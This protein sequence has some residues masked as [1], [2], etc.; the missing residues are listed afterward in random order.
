MP[1]DSINQSSGFQPDMMPIQ[2]SGLEIALEQLQRLPTATA[3]EL[4]DQLLPS[5]SDKESI[6]NTW[7][8]DLFIKIE[9]GQADAL[10][11]LNETMKDLFPIQRA[12][13]LGAAY[14]LALGSGQE[15]VAA[16]VKQE[17]SELFNQCPEAAGINYMTS[18]SISPAT[19]ES[20][21]AELKQKFAALEEPVQPSQLGKTPYIIA[22]GLIATAVASILIYKFGFAHSGRREHTGALTEPAVSCAPG[23]YLEGFSCIANRITRPLEQKIQKKEEVK[24]EVKSENKNEMKKETEKKEVASNTNS[25]IAADDNST[26]SDNNNTILEDAAKQQPKIISLKAQET[27]NLWGDKNNSSIKNLNE[28]CFVLI[29][30][31]IAPNISNVNEFYTIS[32]NVTAPNQTSL[33]VESDQEAK[34]KNYEKMKP[35]HR[36]SLEQA[37]ELL[38]KWKTASSQPSLPEEPKQSQLEQKQQFNQVERFKKLKNLKGSFNE[39]TSALLNRVANDHPD[40]ANYISKAYDY[41][42]KPI[43]VAFETLS[44]VT[45]IATGT[46]SVGVKTVGELAVENYPATKEK[47]VNLLNNDVVINSFKNDPL[48]AEIGST[49]AKYGPVVRDYAM[50]NFPTRETLSEAA[51][52]AKDFLSG[53]WISGS[54][55]VSRQYSSLKN[56]TGEVGSTLFNREEGTISRAMKTSGPI[57]GSKDLPQVQK[58]KTDTEKA[59][60]FE[61]S[62]K[63]AKE[64]QEIMQRMRGSLNKPASK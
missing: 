63:A 52:T 20:F 49:A 43:S 24:I 50:K 34:L 33:P 14:R 16:V 11:G 7:L 1:I 56:F 5:V 58:H 53:A 4:L 46:V 54:E 35:E 27:F 19:P 28:M 64:Q 26:I 17:M 25:T 22:A 32:N 59:R 44:V 21:I 40:A 38:R 36:K 48:I 57:F 29:N 42:S 9:R 10:N 13:V 3:D 39:A 18:L 6:V 30:N 2:K 62:Q 31:E 47:V 51:N 23:Y 55:F 12:V 37:Q 8:E 41:S 45:N 61:E 60:E 15:N